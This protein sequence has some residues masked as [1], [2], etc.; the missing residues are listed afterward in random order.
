MNFWP[1]HL[2]PPQSP[3]LNPLDFSVLAHIEA[4]ACKARNSNRY[5]LKASVNRAWASMK[6]NFVRKACK[7]FCSRLERVIGAKGGH[8]ELYDA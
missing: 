4:R 2:W 5:E 6:K 3:D 8:I 1:K 7:S